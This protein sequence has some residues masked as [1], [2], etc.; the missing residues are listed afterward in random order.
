MV[1]TQFSLTTPRSDSLH[2]SHWA[3]GFRWVMSL[4]FFLYFI[5]LKSIVLQCVA[6]YVT[7]IWYRVTIYNY[8]EMIRKI[9]VANN[10]NPDSKNFEI[11]TRASNMIK[12]V[13]ITFTWLCIFVGSVIILSPVPQYLIKG[14]R[15]DIFPLY[16]PFFDETAY[17]GYFGSLAIQ[18]FYIMLGA[19]GISCSDLLFIV[20]VLYLLPLVEIIQTR[21][22]E[23][24]DLL[25][26]GES[27]QNSKAVFLC[28]RN[29]IKLHQE[30]SK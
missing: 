28:L 4:L 3:F 23:L 29:I 13:A 7:V 6:K 18:F 15:T 14:E 22:E 10:R 5:V 11:L 26:M 16:V 20:P 24:N 9:H 8:F 27:A 12:L 2:R 1:S 21:F 30:I 19:L 17:Y 25:L